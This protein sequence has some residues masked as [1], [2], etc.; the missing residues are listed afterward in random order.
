MLY[1]ALVQANNY[2]ELSLKIVFE[3]TRLG[4]WRN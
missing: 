3:L 2:E 1:N 4:F